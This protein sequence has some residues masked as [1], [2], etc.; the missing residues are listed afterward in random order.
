[1][2]QINFTA[3]RV[4]NFVC[5]SGKNQVF[6]WDATASRVRSKGNP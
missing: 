1:M 2:A 3:G 4:R 5:P 6:I